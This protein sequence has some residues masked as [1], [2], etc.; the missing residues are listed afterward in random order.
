[1]RWWHGTRTGARRAHRVQA[2]ATTPWNP[3]TLRFIEL[4]G[5][6]PDA[7][8]L[9]LNLTI[10]DPNQTAA[11]YDRADRRRDAEVLAPDRPEDCVA[12]LARHRINFCGSLR[13]RTVPSMTGCSKI[14]I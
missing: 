1:M 12:S 9:C 5:I 13:E 8:P 4:S 7:T 11:A 10:V 3:P 14:C 6:S 2:V